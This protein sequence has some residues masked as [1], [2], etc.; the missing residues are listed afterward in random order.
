MNNSIKGEKHICSNC[1]A[2]FFDLHKS[3]IICPKCNTEVLEK[4]SN[5]KAKTLISEPQKN[6]NNIAN[7][8]IEDLDAIENEDAV[9]DIEEDEIDESENDTATSTIVNID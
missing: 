6:N 4:S 5:V 7:E 2:K 1:G 8:S 9:A 3:P